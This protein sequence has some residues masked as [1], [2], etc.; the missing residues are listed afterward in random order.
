MEASPMP[1]DICPT[2]GTS[3]P[4]AVNRLSEF[5]VANLDHNLLVLEANAEFLDYLGRSADDVYGRT[6]SKFVH[7]SVERLVTQHLAGLRAGTRDRFTTRI[8]A[9]RPS[10]T[11]ASGMLTGIAVRKA[12]GEVSGI[13]ML[14]RPD[15]AHVPAPSEADQRKRLSELD[16]RVLEGIA[17]GVSTARLATKL[18]LSRQGIEYHVSAMLR[19]FKTPNRSALVSKAY[20]QGILPVG[21]WPPKV[22]PENIS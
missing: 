21:Q 16:A 10:Y 1:G 18:Y 2:Q 7:P 3:Q 6:F 8:L 22:S 13:V 5:C 4:R 19:R 9:E 11:V 14:L 20:A 15:R 12:A 17:T